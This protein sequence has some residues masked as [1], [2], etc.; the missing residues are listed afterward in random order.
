MEKGVRA[1]FY[2]YKYYLIPDDVSSVKELKSRSSI[3]T[4][5]LKE[6]LCMA[7]DFIYE[8]IV[9]ETV[10]I[11]DG[12]RI[13]EVFVNLYSHEEYDAILREQVDRVCRGCEYY[14][15]EDDPSLN[16]HHREIALT[17]TCYIRQDKNAKYDY[18]DLFDWYW[19]ETSNRL[20]ELAECI[21]KNDQIKLNKILNEN[22]TKFFYETE[23]VGAVI[24]GKY[25]LCIA[26]SWGTPSSLMCL[27]DIIASAAQGENSPIKK[28]DWA[29]LPYI[30]SGSSNGSRADPKTPMLRLKSLDSD[31]EPPFVVEVYQPNAD[32]LDDDETSKLLAELYNGFVYA[33]GEPMLVKTLCE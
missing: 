23:F 21:D 29:V 15:N 28:S 17:G 20:N 12:N 13:F 33:L 5:R 22:L 19:R 7:P 24:D 14:D 27:Y 16:G 32:K 11:D 6:E 18:S 9:D 31:G 26:N 2:D 4:K 25:T 30:P 3:A 10:E 8:S 1:F